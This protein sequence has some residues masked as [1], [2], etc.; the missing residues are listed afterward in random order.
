MCNVK[1]TQVYSRLMS[2][3]VGFVSAGWMPVVTEHQKL[4][5]CVCSLP[6]HEVQF[7]ERGS[8]RRPAQAT[9]T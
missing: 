2:L 6:E 9:I 8:A 5:V 4:T 3:S 7:D 1:A